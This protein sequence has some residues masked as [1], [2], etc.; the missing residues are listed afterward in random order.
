MEQHLR[1]IYAGTSVGVL[2]KDVFIPDHSLALSFIISKNIKT[3][4]LTKQEA[5]LYLKR[6]L[7]SIECGEKGWQIAT[8]NGLGLGWLKNLGNRINNYLPAE[9]RILM[10]IR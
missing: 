5:L 3:C 2:N 4:A 10:D 1:L 7:S 6:E 9:Y 8:F